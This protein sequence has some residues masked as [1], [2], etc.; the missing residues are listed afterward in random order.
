MRHL[1]SIICLFLA[2]YLMSQDTAWVNTLTYQSMTRDTLVHFPLGDHNQYEKILMYYSMRCKG[3]LVSTG[4]DRNKGCGE[5]DYS[6]NTNVIDSSRLDSVRATHPDYI[7]AGHSENYLFYTT[8]PTYTFTDYVLQQV[9]AGNVSG[10]S[11]IKVGTHTGDKVIINSD[12]PAGRF[13]LYYPAGTLSSLGPGNIQGISLKHE[14]S[15]TLRYLNIKIAPSDNTLDSYT[16]L[17]GLT[18]KEVVNRH[19]T[20]GTGG[21]TDIYFHSPYAWNGSS[22]LILE[23]SY[24]CAAAD[25]G[26]L[27]ILGSHTDEGRAFGTLIP[28]NYLVSGT[29]GAGTL[30]SS[31]LGQ[32]SDQVT[33]AFWAR[34]NADVLPNNNSAFY[35]TDDQGRRQLNVHLPWSNG[36][37]FWDCGGDSGGYDR[38]DK[39]ALPSEY[40]GEWNHWAFTKNATTGTMK[41]YLNGSLWHSGTGK[42]RP[43]DIDK[44]S[45]GAVTD[46]SNPYNGHLDDFIVYNRELAAEDISRL[47]HQNPAKTPGLESGLVA[48][49]DLNQNIQ[50]IFEDQSAYQGNLVFNSVAYVLPERAKKYFNEHAVLDALPD[51]SFIKGTLTITKTDVTYRDSVVNPPLRVVPYSV[52]NNQIIAGAPLNY[53]EAVPQQI[54][55][56]DGNLTGEIE[57]EYEG[58][59]DITDLEYFRFSPAKYEI[60]SFVTPYGINLD[61]GPEGKTWIFDVSDYGPILKGSKRLLMDKGG[62]YQEEMDIKFAFIKG[63]PPRNILDIKQIWPVQSYGYTSILNNSQLEP[64]TLTAGSDVRGLKVRTM[65]TGH[66]QE[67]EF[68]SRVHSLNVNGGS[69]EFVWS[70]WKECANNPVYPQ[71]GTWVYDRAGWCPGAPTD[72]REFEITP[73]VQPGSS[74]SLD[75]GL[76]AASGD[77]RYIVNAQLVTYADMNFT[78]DVALEEIINPS[79]RIEYARSNPIC[80]GPVVVIK[81]NGKNTVNSVTFSYGVDNSSPLSYTWAGTLAPLQKQTLALP[82]VDPALL[83][84]GQVFRVTV[85]AVNNTNDQYSGNNILSSPITP[86]KLLDKD[87][88]VTMKTN[89]APSETRWVLTDANGNIIKTSRPDLTAFTMYNDTIRGLSGCYRLQFTDS[90]QDGISWWANGDGD[91]Y[92]RVKPLNGGWVFF[93]PDFGSELTFNFIAALPNATEDVESAAE[94]SVSPNPTTEAVWISL[95]G[96]WGNTRIDVYNQQG[97]PVFTE[98]AMIG[99]RDEYR[100]LLDLSSVPAGLYTVKVSGR[101]IAKAIKVIRF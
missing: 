100:T 96:F 28:G 68:I 93:Q 14:G 92:M 61:L 42:S 79:D 18:Y 71:G 36:R 80:G 81:N 69:S 60:M 13:W 31:G 64:R 90:D 26:S 20:F 17:S 7:I 23:C 27:R 48:F 47:M 29:S 86:V 38:I 15:G 94:V 51:M 43:I 25:L 91:G 78:S 87:I 55:D 41:I 101:K 21:E 62:E 53:W 1:I 33:V 83:Y 4:T 72:L 10:I 57:V 19:V 44:F 6:C 39:A 16:D 73:F 89:G 37:I 56:E 63:T 85:T 66:G 97:I 3:A 9:Q 46:G 52:V 49:F 58:V 65:A 8:D 32:V 77:S 11:R 5:W 84:N 95:S 75:Y 98:S 12:R 22:G 82:D 67:G 34:G 88:V 76:N 59:I 2:S 40:E 30:Q 24:Q 45:V 70:L 54:Y 99:T 50:G 74:F 35:A